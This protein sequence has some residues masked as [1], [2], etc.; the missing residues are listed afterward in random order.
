M[1]TKRGEQ[2]DVSPCTLKDSG[3]KSQVRNPTHIGLSEATHGPAE[4]ADIPRTAATATDHGVKLYVF[5][6]PQIFPLGL[7][8]SEIDFGFNISDSSLAAFCPKVL[9]CRE[10]FDALQI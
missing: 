6:P 2:P 4:R 5:H 9:A 7:R 8:S 1:S 10:D 3:L